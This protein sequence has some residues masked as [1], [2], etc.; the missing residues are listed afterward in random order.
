MQIVANKR[1]EID[2][3]KFDYF[4]RDCHHLGIPNSFDFRYKTVYAAVK[5]IMY[6]Y[7][8]YNRR[9]MK[10]VRVIKVHGV[11]QICARDKVYKL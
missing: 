1:N 10:F 3:D 7:I 5:P 2:V 6:T 4:A 11:L 8:I 9:Y